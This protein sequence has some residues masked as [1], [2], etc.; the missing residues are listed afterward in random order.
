MYQI[1]W[2][3]NQLKKVAL[4]TGSSQGIGAGIAEYLLKKNFFVYITYNNNFELAKQRFSKYKE[5]KMLY[6]DL[7]KKKSIKEVI[8][9][10]NS[11]FGYLNL[12]VNNA[13]VESPGSTELI[14]LSNWEKVFEIG[15]FGKFLI[16]KEALPL[17]KAAK[18]QVINIASNLA[19]KPDYNYSIYCA[20]EAAVVNYSKSQA[21]DFARYGI[22]VNSVNPGATRTN[23]MHI[24]LGEQDNNDYWEKIAA[25]NPLGRVCT[26]EDIGRTI[27]FLT[28]NEA[29]FLNGNEIFVNGGSHLI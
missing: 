9:T 4:I 2:F 12:L 11:D 16:S 17:L 10:I 19:H 13:A 29:D 7:T 8:K 14:D 21:I 25:K 26:P 18:G 6:L 15:L 28:T 20:M 23:M 24:V 22:R 27:Y 5:C 3:P 1:I